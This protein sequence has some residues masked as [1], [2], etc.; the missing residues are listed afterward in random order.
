MNE[1]S[2]A[3]YKFIKEILSTSFSSAGVSPTPEELATISSV[4]AKAGGTWKSIFQGSVEDIALL[5]KVLK[6]A[7]SKKRLTKSSD[8]GSY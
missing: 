8:W 6:V 1:V 4:F 2:R 3:D 5:K 7:I